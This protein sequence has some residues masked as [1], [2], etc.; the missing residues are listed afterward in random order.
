[1]QFIT[2]IQRKSV[3]MIKNTFALRVISSVVE[4][5]I[6]IK[7]QRRFWSLFHFSFTIV[8]VVIRKKNVSLLNS[9]NLLRWYINA[10]NLIAE[11]SP[12]WKF[13]HF[14]KQH[15]NLEISTSYHK[16]DKNGLVIHFN[17]KTYWDNSP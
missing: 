2:G 16:C 8:F 13:Y 17:F 7:L 3:K 10:W 6:V 14:I 15:F 5:I 11:L 1:M 9:L 4:N 12:T